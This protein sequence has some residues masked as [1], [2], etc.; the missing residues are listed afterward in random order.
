M[1]G[2]CDMKAIVLDMH[3]IIVKQTGDDFVP[4]V[5]QTFPRLKA[6]DIWTPWFKVQRIVFM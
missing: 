1:K 6:E 5:Q 4:Y 3:G 2:C